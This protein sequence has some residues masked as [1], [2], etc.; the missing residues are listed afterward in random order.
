MISGDP[1]RTGA[2]PSVRRHRRVGK[3][4][5]IGIWWA[6]LFSAVLATAPPPVLGLQGDWLGRP[7]EIGGHFETR[8]VFRVDRK[9]EHEVNQQI[10]WTDMRYSIADGL[11]VELVLS[12]Q[13]GGPATRTR[14]GGVYNIDDVFQ[15]LTPAFE[16][17]EALLLWEGESFDLRAGQIKYSWGKLDRVQPNDLINPERFADPFLLDEQERK[18]GVP[19]IEAS[20]F[21]PE[22]DWLPAQ[23]RLTA[24]WVPRFVPYRMPYSNERWFPP[25]GIPPSTF[26]VFPPEPAGAEPVLVPVYFETDNRDPPSFQLENS[27]Y[28]L[29]LSGFMHGLDYAVYYQGGLQTSPA[30]QLTA[31]VENDPTSATGFVG[32]TF[33][34]PV[35][36]RIDVW[37]FDFAYAWEHFSL[38]GEAAYTRGRVFNR[39]LRFLIDDPEALTPQILEAVERLRGGEESVPIDIGSSFVVRDA[40]QWGVGV[41][42]EIEGYEALLQID[43][44][45]ILNNDVTL[46]ID[47][48]ETTA[49]ANLRKSFWRGDIGLQLVALYGI[50]SDYTLLMPRFTYRAF[51]W[52]ELELGYLHIAGRQ[53][54]VVGQYK[55][56]DEGFARLRLFF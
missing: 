33:L 42:Y 38:R 41:D 26:P 13:N 3:G 28:A 50:S 7:F 44:T 46:L 8:Q 54:S 56:N 35:F 12:L 5:D 19:S 30:L 49:M 52:A 51:D 32:G 27:T 18:I 2:P 10:L 31:Q 37:G 43:Q 14:R 23:G 40:I 15:S 21:L 48:T 47:D 39:D 45:D 36:R 4:R 20:Y 1:G 22:R 53:R 11:S 9:T 34:S 55:D 24:V 17:Q 29:R 25:A 6:A 16:V